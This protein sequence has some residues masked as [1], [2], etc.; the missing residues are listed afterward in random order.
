MNIIAVDDEH[1]ALLDLEHAIREACLQAEYKKT[2]TPIKTITCFNKADEAIQ[3][4]KT[5]Q[6]HIAFL[7]IDMNGMNGLELAKKLKEINKETNIVFATGHDRYALVAFSLYASDFLLKPVTAKAVA[8]AIENLRHPVKK[9]NNKKL[10]VQCFGNFEVFLNDKPLHFPRKKAKELFAY[11][12][13]KRGTASSTREL[14]AVLYENKEDSVSLQSQVQTVISTMIKV[15][16]DT[17]ETDVII[18][19]RN[20]ISVDITKIDCDY[21]RFLQGDTQAVNAY[22]GEYM[23]NYSWA[24]FTIDYLDN[25]ILK[26]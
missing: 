22:T 6:V 18:K 11:L 20:N 7:D 1:L 24:D 4:A 10:R 23:H 8:E 15:L 26:L 16:N 14:A 21:F 5:T 13:H 19:T 9:A 3:Y 12:I 2:N 17:G 25:K